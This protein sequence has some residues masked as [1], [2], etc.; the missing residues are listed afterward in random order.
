MKGRAVDKKASKGDKKQKKATLSDKEKIEKARKREEFWLPAG[1][2]AAIVVVMV[3]L[4]YV[5]MKTGD[6]QDEAY[7]LDIC[8]M[9]LKKRIAPVFAAY[10][11]E[12]GDYPDSIDTLKGYVNVEEISGE[13]EK[14]ALNIWK[15]F[16]CPADLDKKSYS[17][18]YEKPKDGSP[19]DFIVLKCRV[20]QDKV[21]VKLDDLQKLEAQ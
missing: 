19:S 12:K 9:Q 14:E 15:S 18:V 6:K 13:N 8:T 10:H 2:I 1:I 3:V 11:K 20:H 21:K 5:S 17:Y 4:I 7:N 16:Y